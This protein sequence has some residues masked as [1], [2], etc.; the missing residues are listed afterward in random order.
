M[1]D[2]EILALVRRLERCELSPREFHHRDHLA[3][4]AFYLYSSDLETAMN[5]MRE[6]LLRI[7]KHYGLKGYHETITRFWMERVH[8]RMKNNECMARFVERLQAELSDK[9]LIYRY[10][11]R[12]ALESAHARE[13]WVQPDLKVSRLR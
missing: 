10:Y 8:E 11:S 4:C 2:F 9:D 5:S 13:K 6:S 12:E 3:V 1:T 7:T